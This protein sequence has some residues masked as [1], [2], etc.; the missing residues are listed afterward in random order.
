MMI[1]LCM[2]LRKPPV[3]L[4]DRPAFTLAGVALLCYWLWPTEWYPDGEEM[5]GGFET[6]ILTGVMLVLA[7]A[8]TD[9]GRRPMVG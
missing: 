9:P 2:L 4:P 1:G 3:N 7:K 8:R 6:F 5:S